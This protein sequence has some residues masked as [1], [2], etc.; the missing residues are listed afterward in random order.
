MPAHPVIFLFAIAGY[1]LSLVLYFINFE[2]RQDASLSWA[3]KI[4]FG[5][6]LLHF[7]FIAALFWEEK[8][9]VIVNL[10]EYAVVGAFLIVLVSFGM[11][12]KFKTRFLMLFSLPMALLFSVLAVALSHRGEGADVT[13]S[14]AWLWAH[15]GLIAAGFAGFILAVAGAVMYLLQSRQ[16]KSKQLGRVFLKLPSLSTLDRLH[17]TALAW[18]VVLFSLGILSG[19]AWATEMREVGSVLRDPKVALSFLTCLL[20]WVI[21]AFRLSALR[22]GQKIAVG[23]LLVFALLFVTLMSS[24][25]APTEFHRGF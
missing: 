7:V 18:G 16:L 17:F 2:T 6:L 3:R 10:P 21:L 22:R 14:P 8:R 20:Y 11:E 23:T 9:I 25:Y 4:S 19:L 1:F 12:W 5:S 24:T 15:T 13:A